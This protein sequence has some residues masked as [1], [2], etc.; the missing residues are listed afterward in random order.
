[1]G[2]ADHSTE[3]IAGRRIATYRWGTG[4]RI[5]LLAHGWE[6]RASD[7]TEIVREL[8]TSERTIIAL[9]APGHGKS[10]GKRTTVI[11]YG[12]VLAEM[13][14]NFGPLEAVVSHSLGTPSVATATRSGLR[15]D[16][17]V[18]ISGVA[19]L[20]NLVPRFC[21][22]LGLGPDTVA[23]V[24]TLIED[25]VFDGDRDVWD[26]YSAGRSPFPAESPLLVVHDRQDRM[27]DVK[28][29]ALLADSH[30]PDTRVVTTEG[31]GHNRI[32]SAD[33]VLDEVA[34]FLDVR[35]GAPVLV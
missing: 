33:V 5:I 27:I 18:S 21:E 30:G 20:G 19:D 15:A 9:D 23:R 14:S 13:A 32:L 8:R 1:M 11:E 28:E 4:P 24:R 7:F 34:S 16:R 31:L 29:S 26:H 22:L 3:W 6:G 10:S 2:L 17:Y 25:R 12:Q 35:S